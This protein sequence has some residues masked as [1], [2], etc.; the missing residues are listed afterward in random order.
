MGLWGTLFSIKFL[1]RICFKNAKTM[2]ELLVEMPRLSE[3]PFSGAASA[4]YSSVVI[5]AKTNT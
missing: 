2:Q 1:C 3:T 5:L 4:Q